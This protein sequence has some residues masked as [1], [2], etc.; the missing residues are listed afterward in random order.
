[1][2]IYNDAY[3]YWIK[4]TIEYMELEIK[5]PITVKKTDLLTGWLGSLLVLYSFKEEVN[6]TWDR[7]FLI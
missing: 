5:N 6:K 2:Q 7:I 3:K 1:M 4:V